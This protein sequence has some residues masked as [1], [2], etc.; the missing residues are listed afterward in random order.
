MK[1]PFARR[2]PQNMLDRDKLARKVL[3]CRQTDL[4]FIDKEMNDANFNLALSF[5]E[6]SKGALL[7]AEAL[8]L[9]TSYEA[10]VWKN[11]LDSRFELIDKATHYDRFCKHPWE[12]TVLLHEKGPLTP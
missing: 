3:H 4:T 5:C 7:L 9:I 12:R 11:A 10:A 8:D 2:P 1:L 6:Q